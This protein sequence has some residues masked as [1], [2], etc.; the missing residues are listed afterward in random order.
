LLVMSE[1]M[2][3]SP[4]AHAATRAHA[5]LS[6]FSSW[7]ISLTRTRFTIAIAIAIYAAIALFHA[8]T[9]TARQFP[10]TLIAEW[11]VVPGDAT[12]PITG[13]IFKLNGVPSNVPLSSCSAT[14]CTRTFTI[15]N[16]GVFRVDVQAVNVFGAGAESAVAFTA[17]VPGK[18]A[19]VRVRQQ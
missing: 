1:R 14:T 4:R 16:T 2:A 3:S 10:A 12:F 11:D 18:S 17:S 19:N 9:L 6:R 5:V 8:H 7:R 13:Y 15:P